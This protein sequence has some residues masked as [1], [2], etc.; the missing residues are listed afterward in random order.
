MPRTWMLRADDTLV[1]LLA[2]SPRSPLPD[3]ESIAVP[4]FHPDPAIEEFTE[5]LYRR[6]P[7]TVDG[8]LGAYVYADHPP[9]DSEISRVRQQLTG[10]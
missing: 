5:R 10:S 9:T 6:F 4:E 8:A 2:P 7:V 3:R 1:E